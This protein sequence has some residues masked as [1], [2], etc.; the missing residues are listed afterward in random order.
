MNIYLVR[1]TAYLNPDNIY[2]FHLPVYLSPEGRDHAKRIGEWFHKNSSFGPPIYTSPIV[3]AVQTAEIIAFFIDS[4]VTIDLKL[5]E[6]VSKL[7]GEKQPETGALEYE[8]NYETRESVDSV[9][10]RVAESFDDHKNQ[11]QDCILVSHGDPLTLLLYHLY[12]EESPDDF[13]KRTEKVEYVAR[14]EIVKVKVEE[15]NKY[16]IENIR[17]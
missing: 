4:F 16:T 17:V 7:Q 14:G 10:K 15:N 2:A 6:S 8:Y 1:H 3:R 12:N 5:T 9:R 13:Y 11:N